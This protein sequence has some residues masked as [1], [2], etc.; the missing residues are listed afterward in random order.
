MNSFYSP[1]AFLVSFLFYFLCRAHK[2]NMVDCLYDT[3]EKKKKKK[4]KYEKSIQK[5]KHCVSPFTTEQMKTSYLSKSQ[6]F[7]IFF[8]HFHLAYFVIFPSK[9]HVFSDCLPFKFVLTITDINAHQTPF[10]LNF[11]NVLRLASYNS[12]Q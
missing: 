11:F 9:K 3:R 5:R 8:C 1:F 12:E 7:R 4:K 2:I 10:L 6:L